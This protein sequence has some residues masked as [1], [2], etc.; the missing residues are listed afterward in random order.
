VQVPE[1]ASARIYIKVINGEKARA[2]IKNGHSNRLE[3]EAKSATTTPDPYGVDQSIYSEIE[4]AYLDYPQSHGFD[5]S[6]G[7][8]TNQ[9]IRPRN[10]NKMVKLS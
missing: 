5:Q 2:F 10:W 3:K 8:G 4:L 1:V 7:P 6:F 9:K